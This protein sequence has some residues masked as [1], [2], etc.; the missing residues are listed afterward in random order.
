MCLPNLCSTAS[1]SSAV[2][3]SPDLPKQADFAQIRYWNCSDFADANSDLAEITEKK[4][5]HDK[6]AF[7]EHENST[8]FSKSEI[9]AVGK[10]VYEVFQTLLDDGLAPK[11]W[12]Q[13]SSRATNI[14]RTDL[15]AKFPDIRLCANN[16]KADPLAS[17]KYAQWSRRRKDKISKSSSRKL[18]KS[19]KRKRQ[20][21]SSELTRPS[22]RARHDHSGSD[23]SSLKDKHDRSSSKSKKKQSKKSPSSHVETPSLPEDAEDDVDSKRRHTPEPSTPRSASHSPSPP[24][25]P[26]SPA[27]SPYP[28]VVPQSQSRSPSPFV[29]TDLQEVPAETPIVKPGP[30]TVTIP[31]PLGNLFP[32]KLPPAGP[33]TTPAPPPETEKATTKR[34]KSKA[35]T[36]SKLAKKKPHKPGAADTACIPLRNLFG[37]EHMKAH[38]KATSDEVRAAW[39]DIDQ[40]TYTKEARHLKKLK[41]EA[42]GKAKTDAVNSEDDENN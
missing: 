7:L 17:E 29:P 34:S 6:L 41:K 23:K 15:L 37:R 4:N 21:D 40:S 5:R 20:S 13:A 12:S 36:Q 3:K 14:L 2:N 28:V 42:K 10:A 35:D 11:T 9:K 22:K 32:N 38:P 30:L 24:V 33:S 39:K 16:W 31:N 19:S 25:V 1:D 8:V 26:H 18:E 27:H